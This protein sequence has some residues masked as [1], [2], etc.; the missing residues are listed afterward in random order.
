MPPLPLSSHPHPTLGP[1]PA[2]V[3]APLHLSWGS[4][5]T[6][7]ALLSGLSPPLSRLMH[8]FS[9]C[10]KSSVLTG[11]FSSAN[12]LV[13]SLTENCQVCL[14]PHPSHSPPCGSTNAPSPRQEPPLLFIHPLPQAPLALCFFF[15]LFCISSPSLSQPEHTQDSPKQQNIEHASLLSV[16]P[17]FITLS[18]P[19]FSGKF[20]KRCLHWSLQ[21]FLTTSSPP[22]LWT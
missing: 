5:G 13:S 12:G 8:W 4:C 18:P 17:S 1:K 3:W 10:P 15:S 2:C 22:A 14:A 9:D 20:P 16:S 11:H 21:L 6:Q 19:P 7:Q